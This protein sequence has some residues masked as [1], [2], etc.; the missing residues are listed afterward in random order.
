MTVMWK[1]KFFYGL[2]FTHIIFKHKVSLLGSFTMIHSHTYT[3]SSTHKP[4][5]SLSFLKGHRGDSNSLLLTS[6][7]TVQAD[8]RSRVN[9]SANT[10]HLIYYFTLHV[11]WK[12]KRMWNNNDVTSQF[13]TPPKCKIRCHCELRWDKRAYRLAQYDASFAFNLLAMHRLK[14]ESTNTVQKW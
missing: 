5:R 9:A 14:L 7:L 3:D 1:I 11:T 4:V 2:N 10:L 13:S 12:S 6:F 8:S